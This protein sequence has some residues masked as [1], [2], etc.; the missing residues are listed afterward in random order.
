MDAVK[1]TVNDD[2]CIATL[3]DGKA[4]ALSPD[5]IAALNAALDRAEKEARAVVLLGRP[6]RFSAGFDLNVMRRGADAA[7]DLVLA[8]AHF[9]LRLLEL[10]LPVVAGCTGHAVA[11][12]ALLLLCSD[13]RIGADGDFRI[14][15]N[16]V[17][18]GMTLPRFGVELARDRLCPRSVTPA[19]LLA[20][21]FS[22]EEAQSAG[23]LDELCAASDVEDRVLEEGR[24]LRD[25]SGPAFAG[26]KRRLRE[27]VVARIRDS[28]ERDMRELLG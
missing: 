3:D 24:R 28:L 9:G 6:G 11:M 10:P 15:L 16:E 21:M 13:R 26:T 27:R 1:V 4:N 23:F 5:V 17:G 19:T 18:I 14:G 7:R 22:P 25:L 20:H 2:V 12:G 8:G